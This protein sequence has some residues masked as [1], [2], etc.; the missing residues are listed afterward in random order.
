MSSARDV[1]TPQE[2]LT[3]QLLAWIDEKPRGYDELIE[4]WKTNCPR[5]PIWEDAC[6]EGLVGVE[7]ASP[8]IVYLT[9]KGR[10]KLAAEQAA[11]SP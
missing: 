5:F 4:A 10:R 11:N 1:K 2:S 9:A 8:R 3:L 7:A 6:D